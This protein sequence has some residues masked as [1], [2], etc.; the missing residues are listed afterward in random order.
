MIYNTDPKMK[1]KNMNHKVN[2]QA[3]SRGVGTNA[4]IRATPTME[5]RKM[6]GRISWASPSFHS[7]PEK[8]S[9]VGAA[10]T[11]DYDT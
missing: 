4:S 1:R 8:S 7:L 9:L 3:E 5:P 11:G 6:L 10:I 2:L